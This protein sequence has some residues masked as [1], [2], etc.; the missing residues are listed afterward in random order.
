MVAGI[1]ARW[2]EAQKDQ[3][4]GTGKRQGTPMLP[5][6]ECKG[7]ARCFCHDSNKA[8]LVCSSA[9]RFAFW[10]PFAPDL[11]LRLGK[12]GAS[13]GCTA[14]SGPGMPQLPLITGFSSPPGSGLQ[15]LTLSSSAWHHVPL[16]YPRKL[17]NTVFFSTQPACTGGGCC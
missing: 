12:F 2:Q 16:L 8:G 9:S 5:I 11:L 15:S 14:E 4:L 10:T 7:C 13:W 6:T 3:Y 17:A 1:S